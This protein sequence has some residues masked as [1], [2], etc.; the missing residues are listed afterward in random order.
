MCHII[1]RRFR[2]KYSCNLQFLLSLQ[3][4]FLPLNRKQRPEI[5]SNPHQTNNIKTEDR[6]FLTLILKQARNIVVA[7]KSANGLCHFHRSILLRNNGLWDSPRITS[8]KHRYILW[9]WKW[10][11]IIV[12]STVY[13]MFFHSFGLL[14]ELTWKV[15]HTCHWK[16]TVLYSVSLFS[17]QFFGS[18]TFPLLF[19]VYDSVQTAPN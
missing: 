13:L 9:I 4:T 2:I 17:S 15:L 3:L 19:Q 12:V 6:T 8:F 7:F 10:T 5:I 14:P 18:F 11:A 1:L 16:K